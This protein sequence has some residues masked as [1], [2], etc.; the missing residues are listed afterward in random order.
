MIKRSFIALWS[1][2]ACIL[3]GTAITNHPAFLGSLLGY[4]VGFGYTLWFHRETLRSSELDIRSAIKRMRLNFL[5]RLGAIT[6]VVVAVARF[7]RSWLSSLAIGIAVGVIVSF[8][9][10]AIHQIT[11][12]RGY[13]KGA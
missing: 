12:E 11:N 1:G 10:V 6:L 7:Q 2:T 5:M 9:I 4:W 3:L 13:K 8:I